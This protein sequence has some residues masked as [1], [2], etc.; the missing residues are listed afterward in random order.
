M[1]VLFY[2][3]AVVAVLSTLMV[4]TR[5]NLVHALVYLVISLFA[6]AVVFY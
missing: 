4:V 2:I 5:H 1:T 3:A 6:V